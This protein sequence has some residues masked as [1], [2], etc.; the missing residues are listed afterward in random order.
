MGGKGG[1]WSTHPTHL[2]QVQGVS[3]VLTQLLWGEGAGEGRG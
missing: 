1:S 2:A 3:G